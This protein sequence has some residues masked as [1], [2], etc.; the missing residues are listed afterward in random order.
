MRWFM[1]ADTWL[2]DWPVFVHTQNQVAPA[3]CV[4][5]DEWSGHA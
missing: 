2:G 1:P 4:A 3:A 5:L